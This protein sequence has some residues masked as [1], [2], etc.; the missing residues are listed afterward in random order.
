MY[1]HTRYPPLLFFTIFMFHFFFQTLI[2]WGF[3]TLL[4]NESGEKSDRKRK[5]IFLLFWDKKVAAVVY[6]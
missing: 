2:E 1:I 5:R 6:A 4:E 3:L